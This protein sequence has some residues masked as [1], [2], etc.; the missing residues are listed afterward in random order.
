MFRK[1]DLQ[2]QVE[3]SEKLKLGA[4]KGGREM[5]GRRVLQ[6]GTEGDQVTAGGSTSESCQALVRLGEPTSTRGSA[7]GG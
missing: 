6:K 1:R 3:I 7:G 4:K 2:N 5:A